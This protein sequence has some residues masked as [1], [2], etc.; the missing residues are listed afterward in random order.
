VTGRRPLLLP[1]LWAVA[2]AVALAVALPAAVRHRD[3][4]H[5]ELRRV[6]PRLLL[7]EGELGVVPLD[8]EARRAEAQRMLDDLAAQRAGHPRSV[9]A[10]VIAAT[11]APAQRGRRLG[12]FEGMAR[13]WRDDPNTS[14]YRDY[15]LDVERWT[16]IDVDGANARVRFIGQ[17]RILRNPNAVVVAPRGED[18]AGWLAYP[19]ERF[20]VRLEKVDGNWQLVEVAHTPAD[21]SCLSC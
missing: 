3:E 9:E 5:D 4:V 19:I 8:P 18:P 7:A 13:T 10:A 20:D 12:S 6:V 21:G 2:T 11:W 14:G 17:Q 1:G 16:S 15:R